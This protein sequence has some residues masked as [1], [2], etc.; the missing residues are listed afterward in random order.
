MP[1]VLGT[2]PPT[3][4]NPQMPTCNEPETHH[5]HVNPMDIMAQMR[6][7]PPTPS[8]I[9]NFNIP[10]YTAISVLLDDPVRLEMGYSLRSSS[11]HGARKTHIQISHCGAPTYAPK[12]L[13]TPRLLQNFHF[14]HRLFQ[15]AICMLF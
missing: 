7:C 10:R 1:S 11:V 12:P 14:R 4:C 5:P 8:F 3:C 15:V 6:C 9:L 2:S 13:S